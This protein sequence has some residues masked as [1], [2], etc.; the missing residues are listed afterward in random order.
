MT[1]TESTE[2]RAAAQIWAAWVPEGDWLPA[3]TAAND[4]LIAAAER[5]AN[6]GA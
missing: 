6:G 5:A 3:D 4:E 2:P 1:M